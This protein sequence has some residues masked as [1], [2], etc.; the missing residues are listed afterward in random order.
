L[1]SK[2]S[3][4]A[5]AAVLALALAAEAQSAPGKV[6]IVNV[7]QAI[8]G[9]K[10]GQKASQQLDSKYQPKQKDFE[11]RQADIAQIQE[12]LNK[13]GALLSEEKRGEMQRDL[14]QKRRSL[15]R[16]T[17]DARDELAAD[18]Q[19][20]LQSLGQ[21]MVALIEKYA[22]DNGY[23][24][25]LDVS[26]PN[27]PVV[28]ASPAVDITKDIVAIYDNANSGASGKTPAAQPK[29]PGGL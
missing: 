23:S 22:K 15:D 18:Q 29:A 6:G 28:Y 19:K 2:Q 4:C 17:S 7:Q 1:A 8:V 25:I 14:D 3:L 27:T 10:D 26:S 24:L 16:D 13:T 9:T 21:K 20:I 11:K 12:Q 5:V